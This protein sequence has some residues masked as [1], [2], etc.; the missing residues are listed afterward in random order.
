[1]QTIKHSE[2]KYREL[3]E[4]TNSI[5]IKIDNN[6]KILFIN[7]YG[8]SFFGYSNEELIGRNIV[9]TILSKTEKSRRY[10]EQMI[11]N[12]LQYPE[13]YERNEYENI[14]KT[15][16]KVWVSWTN[17]LIRDNNGNFIGIL[18]VGNNITEH[19]I[20][21]QKLKARDVELKNLE[22]IV[23]H[24]P[25]IVFLWRNAEGWPVDFVSDNVR[26]FGYEPEEFYFGKISY[27][28]LIYSDDLE[29][30]GNEVAKYS[31]EGRKEF[32]QEYRILTK[33]GKICWLDDRTWIRRNSMGEI[34]HYQGI[35]LD[36]TNRKLAEEQ[37]RESEEKF[38]TITE[39]SLIGIGIIQ[40]NIIKYINHRIEKIFECDA[41]ELLGLNIND[42][43]NLVHHTNRKEILEQLKRIQLSNIKNYM[44]F[45]N[46]IIT[47]TG[48]EKWI[49]C[50]IKDITYK[51][52]P[53]ILG[54]CADIT[55][56]KIAEFTINEHARKLEILNKIILAVN[57][58]DELPLLLNKALE[59]TIELM[60]FDA[61]AI[62]LTK[63]SRKTAEFVCH[64]GLP[65]DFINMSRRQ[66]LSESSFDIVFIHG[67]PIFSE[68][69]YKYEPI[70]TAKWG[71]LSFASI[72]LYAKENVIGALNIASKTRHIFSIQEKDLLLSIGRELGSAI[73]KMK[74]EEAL[75]ES[76]KFLSNIFTSI[77]DGICI[78]DKSYKI[79]QV[80]PTMEKWYSHLL[81]LIGKQCYEIFCNSSHPCSECLCFKTIEMKKSVFK[82]ISKKV[83]NLKT[84]GI[85]EI[86]TYPFQDQETGKI[87]GIV[88]YIR[89]VSEHHKVKEKLRESE[90]KSRSILENI[91]EGYFEVDILGNFTFINDVF[92]NITGYSN[93]EIIQTNF[94]KYIDKYTNKKVKQF[95]Y[96]VYETEIPQTSF[97]FEIIKRN[98]VKIF[99]ET[100]VYL[101]YDSEGNKIGFCGL[102][103]DITEK[104]KAEKIIKAE[105]KK[106][107]ELDKLKNEFVY[108]ASHELK[109]PLN[110]I[111]SASNLLLEVHKNK[112]DNRAKELI[113]IIKKGGDRLENLIKNLL[114]VSKFESGK[115]EL[116]KQKENLTNIIK[117]TVKDLFYLIEE[118]KMNLNIDINEDIY[119]T[120]D[121]VRIEQ[122]FV[123]L[124]ANALNYTPPKGLIS[125]NVKNFTNF[126]EIYIKD[127]GIGF[128]E[129]EKD[130]IFKK[131]G[132]IEH[133]GKG[134][135][136]ITEG[137]GLGL[138]ISKE[139][140]ELHEGK[141]SVESKGRSKGSTFII[142]L[143]KN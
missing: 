15:G 13:N 100:S 113:E 58:T 29:R 71:I 53:A 136:I 141:I 38:R 48:K 138:Y 17:K 40:E 62:Y 45:Q 43:I 93:D 51:R 55:D 33:S 135:N 1:E 36:I 111:S 108:R 106:L 41:K 79:L 102:V 8:E 2:E 125:I 134:L 85:L 81:P 96:N 118:R 119:L 50:I 131:F 84:D 44:E 24:S 4:N 133:Y 82:T 143:P 32:V 65:L 94:N 91:K 66:N 35:V 99:I 28:D 73:S 86:Y 123:N 140:I 112:L 110:S 130:K 59:A 103:R 97:Q 23:N 116:N 70:I 128:T 89:D 122:V 22:H 64:K 21:E 132:K 63:G 7:E 95:F 126:I 72:P 120:I 101:R 5:I 3:V 39:Q 34:T 27:A 142:R 37:L 49:N 56:L 42:F 9:G 121:K 124:I 6:G 117:E 68:K 30:V 67:R 20:A 107:K 78:I 26:Q 104:K 77:Q 14:T 129:E 54:I 16:K 114:D 105:I 74:A 61:G 46:R 76:K 137:S 47:K 31:E 92:C 69:Y 127:N 98:N 87:T 12:I 25:A 90:E 80:N 75:K 139:I 11:K 10:L 18:F 109:T 83:R 57:K 60:N 115:L 19:K 88:E 52:K